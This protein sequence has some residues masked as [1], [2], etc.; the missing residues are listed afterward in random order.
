MNRGPKNDDAFDS[1]ESSG[2]TTTMATVPAKTLRLSELEESDRTAYFSVTALLERGK[3]VAARSEPPAAAAPPE[4]SAP[5]VPAER[6]QVTYLAPDTSLPK[7][8]GPWQ[9]LREASLA[10][11]AIVVMLPL[12]M[13]VLVLEPAAKKPRPAAGTSAA[14]AADGSP[15]APVVPREVTAEDAPR[16]LA[17][18]PAEPPPA[19]PKGVSLERA[20]TDALSAGDFPRALGLYRELSKREPNNAAYREATRILER[21]AKEKLP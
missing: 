19:L 3:A 11:K 16:L 8:P 7:K 21:R 10:K 1:E 5:P 20:A 2:V 12:L 13:G 17:T 6:P 4:V 9:Q 14:A 18:T 15:H